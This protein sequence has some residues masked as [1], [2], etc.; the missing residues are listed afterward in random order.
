MATAKL[1][2]DSV[3]LPNP[4]TVPRGQALTTMS[5]L[6]SF[7]DLEHE[8]APGPSI[9]SPD[10][11]VSIFTKFIEDFGVVIDFKKELFHFDVIPRIPLR[12]NMSST[13]G[14]DFNSS[15]F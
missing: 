2:S 6:I 5:D 13:Q 14:I 12:K 9:T 15:E 8:G 1:K 7:D 10:P 4:S 11:I 3:K